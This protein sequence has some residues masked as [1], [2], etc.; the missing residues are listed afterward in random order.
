MTQERTENIMAQNLE[1]FIN[2]YNT[3]RIFQIFS[4]IS[5]IALSVLMFKLDVFSQ[6]DA[7][8]WYSSGLNKKIFRIFYLNANFNSNVE[9]FVEIIVAV[10]AIVGII[11]VWLNRPKVSGACGGALAVI[12]FLS[13]LRM[14]DFEH[15]YVRT[16]ELLG[17]IFHIVSVKDAYYILWGALAVLI[18]FIILSIMFTKQGPRQPKAVTIVEVPQQISL[19]D[20]IKK[21]KDLLDSGA[22]TQEEFDTK[23]KEILEK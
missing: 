23:K 20:E 13:L 9:K 15:Y 7:F 14:Y 5:Y 19:A 2:R 17:T 10:A 11:F 8:S 16:S 6:Y 1:N 3:P 22:I 4:T 21:Y 18:V 12:M